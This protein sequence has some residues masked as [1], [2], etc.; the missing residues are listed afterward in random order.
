MA[1]TQADIDALDRAIATGA[2]EVQRGDERVRYR[3]LPD[4]RS[5]LEKM[6]AELAGQAAPKRLRRVTPPT[7]RGL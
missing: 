7:S 1:V 6:K 5:I 4:M 3:S 2:T